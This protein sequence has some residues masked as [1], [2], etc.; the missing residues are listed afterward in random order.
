MLTRGDTVLRDGLLSISKEGSQEEL[1][2][3]LNGTWSASECRD[4]GQLT[5]RMN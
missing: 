1:L 3:S 4:A 5:Q 2:H